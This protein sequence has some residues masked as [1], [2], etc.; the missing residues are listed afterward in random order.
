MAILTSMADV[1]GKESRARALREM[2]VARLLGAAEG[3]LPTSVLG[4]FGK[5]ALAGLRGRQLFRGGDPGEVDVESLLALVGSIGELKGTAMKIGQ[6][7]SYIDVALPDELRAALSALQTASPPMSWDTVRAIV[8][9]E[10]GDRAPAFLAHMEPA[11][12]AAASI[13]QVHRAALPDGTRVAVKVRYPDID[14]AIA[15]DF[16]PA[17]LGGVMASIIFPGAKVDSMMRELRERLLAECDYA[18]EARAQARFCEDKRALMKLTLPG[19][20]LFLFRIRF[21]LM[22]VLARLGA[23]TNWFRLEE[24]FVKRQGSP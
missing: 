11:P 22:S 3:R 2:L 19:E 21:G 15:A 23:R 10:L 18:A 8:S 12:V 16:V 5:S 1:D 7:M 17:A 20:F 14:K 24:R 6:I 4:R 13:G 9:A